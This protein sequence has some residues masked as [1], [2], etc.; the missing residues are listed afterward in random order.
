MTS[1]E[2]ELEALSRAECE[3]RGWVCI[4]VRAKGLHGKSQ[5]LL[6][7]IDMLAAPSTPNTI[8][9]QITSASNMAARKKKVREHKNLPLARALGW[10]VR[11]WAFRDDRTLRE[12]LI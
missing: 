3:R 9:I 10:T 2:A 1:R 8:A 5:D 11:V 7:F 4:V 12:A 6:G